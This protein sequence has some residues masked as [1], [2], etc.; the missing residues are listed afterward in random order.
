[1]EHNWFGKWVRKREG[2]REG[3]GGEDE[4]RDE[5][6][7]TTTAIAAALIIAESKRT[8]TQSPSHSFVSSSLHSLLCFTLKL[9][10]CT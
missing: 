4:R 10:R 6:T 8:R 1:L 3:K 5:K 7:T 2:R 9:Q